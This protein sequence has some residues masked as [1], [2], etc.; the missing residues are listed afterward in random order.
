M[1]HCPGHDQLVE[2]IGT[3]KGNVNALLEGQKEYKESIRTLTDRVVDLKVSSAVEKTKIK[4]FYIVL[5][6]ITVLAVTK[7]GERVVLTI[8]KLFPFFRD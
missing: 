7:I 6:I 2:D 1:E 8:M 3:I 4:P 5:G